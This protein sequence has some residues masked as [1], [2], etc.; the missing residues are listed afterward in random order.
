MKGCALRTRNKGCKE[1]E[2]RKDYE[3]GKIKEQRKNIQKL[4]PRKDDVTNTLTGVQKDNMLMDN[5]K[6]RRL[7]PTECERLQG[8]PDGWTEKGVVGWEGDGDPYGNGG[9]IPI[10]DKISDTQR[11]KTLGNAVTVNVIRDIICQL[12]K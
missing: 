11:Y 4:E 5:S 2:I 8:F 10:V 12:L 9:E 3:A 7:T 1:L 6:I